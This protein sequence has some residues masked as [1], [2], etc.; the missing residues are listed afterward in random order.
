MRSYVQSLLDDISPVLL[1]KTKTKLSPEV[2]EAIN[3]AGRSMDPPIEDFYD[4]LRKGYFEEEI[5][6]Q[7]VQS[8][9]TS[10]TQKALEAE[11][12]KSVKLM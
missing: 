8:I 6:D 5:A 12:A 9:V 3:S 1:D 4:E 10:F 7:F 11:R 2:I